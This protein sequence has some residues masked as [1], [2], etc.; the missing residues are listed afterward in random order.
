MRSVILSNGCV[1][2][3]QADIIVLVLII[4]V[5][6]HH[7]HHHWILIELKEVLIITST[8]TT[9]F[10]VAQ[11]DVL[12]IYRLCILITISLYAGFAFRWAI[13]TVNNSH[14]NKR[15]THV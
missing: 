12:K 14:E 9:M 1:A 5:P 3:E 8:T 4:T 6:H 15:S 7:F 11:N 2:I 10:I 13:I